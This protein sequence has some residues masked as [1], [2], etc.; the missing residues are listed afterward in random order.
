ML[1]RGDEGVAQL[2]TP[3]GAGVTRG[4]EGRIVPVFWVGRG[5]G[6]GYAVRYSAG[7]G[8]HSRAGRQEG[9]P[10]V[11]VCYPVSYSGG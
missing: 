6:R 5:G 7:G 10:C 3:R 9:S 1:R 2:D 8:G 4:R 11:F